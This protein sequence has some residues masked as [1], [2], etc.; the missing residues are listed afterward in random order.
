MN[1]FELKLDVIERDASGMLVKTGTKVFKPA[2][3][4]MNKWVK[5]PKAT[6]PAL[7]MVSW[8]PKLDGESRSTTLAKD[9][10]GYV[11]S[12][13]NDVMNSASLV[14]L[15]SSAASRANGWPV[16]PDNFLE[17]LVV[18][19]CRKLVKPTWLNDRDEFNVPLLDHPA[20]PQ[21]ALDCV[22]YA[23]FNGANY[24]SS[25]DPV[26]YKGRT[27]ELRNQFFW[28]TADFFKQITG[29]PQ[30]IAAQ[31][32][33]DP[34]VAK[35]LKGKTFSPDAQAVLEAAT[36]MVVQSAGKRGA[37]DPK[38]QLHRW[39]A[40]WYQIKFGLFAK[41]VKFTPTPRMTAAK[42]KFDA[43]YDVFRERMRP[44]LY[45]LDVLPAEKGLDE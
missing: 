2:D 27:F 9:S 7:P 43:A 12:G 29:M 30:K 14:A 8:Y 19:A 26:E 36:D 35:W 41:D 39:D 20:Y 45:E 32:K 15:H 21:F 4:P 42:E 5:R 18:M 33:T 40:G 3:R 23:L 22:I 11:V 10:L 16:T 28:L 13:G 17:S 25:L 31:A 44:M 34:F 37:A 1:K 6:E 38:Y 24:A